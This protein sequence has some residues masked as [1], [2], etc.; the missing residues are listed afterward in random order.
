M[1]R[2][3]AGLRTLLLVCLC[4]L[5]GVAG[6]DSRSVED[7]VR[8]GEAALAEG[9]TSL[10]L[11]E[12]KNAVQQD[13]QSGLAR[14]AL[15]VAHY[16]VGDLESARKELERAIDLG[17]EDER[18]R[19][20]LLMVKNDSGQHSEVI[21]ELE[22]YGALTPP[23]AAQLAMA[24][25]Y[26]G[27]AARAKPL[28][29]QAAQLPEG[30][31]GLAELA[32]SEND[33]TQMWNYAE[34][35]TTEYPDYGPGWMFLAEARLANQEFESALEAFGGVRKV[36]RYRVMGRLG[37]IRT[38]IALER[39]DEAATQIDQVL[40][41]GKY[42]PALYLQGLVRFQQEDFDGAEDALRAVE[43]QAR[44]HPPTMY[45]MGA[46]KAQ[47][48]EYVQATEYLRRYLV[49][50]EKNLSARKLLASVQTASG[51]I[52]AAIETLEVVAP[53]ATDAQLVAML[54]QA[55]LSSGDVV[56]ATEHFERA[57]ELAPNSA[58]F[59][60]RL[61][62]GLLG[63]GDTSRAQSELDAAVD[64][65]SNQMESDFI[66]V[67]MLMN[68]G[69]VEGAKE[70]IAGL[71][72][73]EKESP[74]GYHL[75][76][77]VAS[78]EGDDAAAEAQFRKAL[79]V[80]PGYVPAARQ[81]VDM[82]VRDEDLNAAQAT[83]DALVAAAPQQPSALLL[84]AEVYERQ[85]RYGDAI[86][87]LLTAM[88]QAPLD[89]NVRLNLAR[90]YRGTD[91]LERAREVLGD[92]RVADVND[93]TLLLLR[94]DIEGRL[95]NENE[96]R[97]LVAR[98]QGLLPE[99]PDDPV[100]HGAVGQLQL[101]QTNLTLARNNLERALELGRAP[102][103]SLIALARLE[104]IEGNAAR[105]QD[106]A[107]QL[108]SQGVGGETLELLQVD[109][110]LAQNQG[111]EALAVLE[112]LQQG[113]SRQGTN[114][115][116]LLLLQEGRSA[117]AER[118][119]RAWLSDQPDDPGMVMMLANVLLQTG[120]SQGA[121]QQYESLLPVEDPILLNNLAWLYMR[122]GDPRAEEMARRANAVAPGTADIEDT[123]GWILLNKGATAEALQLLKSAARALPENAEVQY[124]LGSAYSAAGQKTAAKAALT[125]AVTLG[126]FADVAKA[127]AMLADL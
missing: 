23:F 36:P 83:A 92:E 59:R 95:G 24:Y 89:L 27:D 96:V 40:A 25:F 63:S 75:S 76:G 41:Q 9:D 127:E 4:F 16:R 48:Q 28:F 22:E 85:Q 46:V 74:V 114:A 56:K 45:L 81:L 104:I 11:I 93:P 21:G 110:Y 113:G 57:V 7:R 35:V 51:K 80:D 122:D 43:Q 29:Q 12:L 112:G 32:R 54:G 47:K 19:L 49:E 42:L 72:E 105:A 31:L 58:V 98:L 3:H 109:I 10:A 26:A 118:V 97:R 67:M 125:K 79:E 94:A 106:I 126:G 86:E 44:N 101:R 73:R 50:D 100:L 64:L 120:D 121:K 6:C 17:V 84:Q 53:T 68:E 38:L 5:G 52:D 107:A 116:A 124:H 61:A 55:Y 60:N 20:H 18:T 13:P 87:V 71:I 119:L 69:D 37:E 66:A 65:D 2:V 15:G 111:P 90:L 102:V 91:D 70:R 117:E 1:I 33:L 34:R 8:D 30:L 78:G 108:T 99:Y 115:Y 39:L 103:S 77:L 82:A 14:A 62:I 88:G 123:L